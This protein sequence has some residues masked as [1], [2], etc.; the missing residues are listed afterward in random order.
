MILCVPI[1][2][3]VVSLQIM[4]VVI[5]ILAQLRVAYVNALMRLVVQPD[6]EAILVV[7]QFGCVV[8]LH[9]LIRRLV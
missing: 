1:Q 5:L 4:G 9:L 7:V 6:R 8:I 3:A 2:S